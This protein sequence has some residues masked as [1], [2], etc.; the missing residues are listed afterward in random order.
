MGSPA[1]STRSSAHPARSFNCA[2]A[3]QHREPNLAGAPRH[4]FGDAG[5]ITLEEHAAAV[6]AQ[7]VAPLSPD[8]PPV[9]LG[10]SS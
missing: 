8:A 2:K 7:Q 6:V 5:N 4:P 3:K 1:S 10:S 9:I